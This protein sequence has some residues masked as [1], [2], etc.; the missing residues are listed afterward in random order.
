MQPT[1]GA[2]G[3]AR[4]DAN[5]A[6]AHAEVEITAWPSPGKRATVELESVCAAYRPHWAPV[7]ASNVPD[8]T[9]VGMALTVIA[10]CEIGA[11]GTF[12]MRQSSA[13][14]VNWGG[15]RRTEV[16]YDGKAC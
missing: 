2:L 15:C 16:G 14:K 11:L 7:F 10:R 6:R 5:T 8:M 9:S 13:Q 1:S 12:Q 3:V 4:N